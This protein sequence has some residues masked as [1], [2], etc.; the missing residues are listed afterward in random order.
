MTRVCLYYPQKIGLQVYF[1]DGVE[2]KQL[3]TEYVKSLWDIA[4]LSDQ[5]EPET[6][7]NHARICIILDDEYQFLRFEKIGHQL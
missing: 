1:Y 5:F 7:N 6:D 4:K 3:L 2:Y